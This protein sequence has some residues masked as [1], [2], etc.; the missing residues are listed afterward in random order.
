MPN[1]VKKEA[2]EIIAVSWDKVMELCKKLARDI[3]D[4]GF[5]PSFVFGV[6]NGGLVPA[7]LLVRELAALGFQ[8][9]IVERSMLKI[10]C[11][12]Y[13]SIVIDEIVDSGDTIKEYVDMDNVMTVT[14]FQRY[15]THTKAE[16]VG[17]AINHDNWLAF[18]W[19]PA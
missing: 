2:Q 8:T 15:S 12:Q 3:V 16:L 14:L 17:E 10:S 5:N 11:E 18:P 13:K 19:E 9:E 1:N 6:P 7:A 4:S